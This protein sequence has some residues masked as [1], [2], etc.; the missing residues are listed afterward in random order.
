M[1]ASNSPYRLKLVHQLFSG[2]TGSLPLVMVRPS[3]STKLQWESVVMSSR[4]FSMIKGLMKRMQFHAFQLCSL[5]VI[6]VVVE[7]TETLLPHL[8]LHPMPIRLLLA[9]FTL[10]GTVLTLT[11]FTVSCLLNSPRYLL[12]LFLSFKRFPTKLIVQFYFP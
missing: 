10:K 4:G 2:V 1:Q 12:T 11:F 9:E 3:L 7:G 6:Q 5:K 8:L